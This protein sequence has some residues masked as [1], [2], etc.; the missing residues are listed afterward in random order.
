MAPSC[1]TDLRPLLNSES[2]RP[3]PEDKLLPTNALFAHDALARLLGTRC[4]LNEEK[5]ASGPSRISFSL[6]LS[7]SQLAPERRLLLAVVWFVYVH[8]DCMKADSS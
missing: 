1:A 7:P 8:G 3:K 5:Y 4:G 2:A 6:S